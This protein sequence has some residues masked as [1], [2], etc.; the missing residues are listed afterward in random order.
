MEAI[1]SCSLKLSFLYSYDVIQ[2]PK[3][4]TMRRDPDRNRIW[5]SARGKEEFDK[6]NNIPINEEQNKKKHR[7][8]PGG[9][10]GRGGVDSTDWI[11]S[12]LTKRFGLVGGLK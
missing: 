3:T 4:Q 2:N 8:Q 6:R 10:V 12:S 11:A 1:S 9:G 5:G 7:L